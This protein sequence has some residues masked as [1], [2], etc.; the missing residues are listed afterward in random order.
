QYADYALW[1]RELLG[2]EDNPQSVIS[3]QVGYWR[4]A[5]ADAPE[6]LELPFDHQRP[7]V[8]SHQG[9][10]VPFAVPAAVHAQAARVARSE[11]ATT[12]MVLQAALAMVLS[13]SGAGTDIPIGTAVA[14]RTDADLGDL[15]GFFVNTLVMRTD[16][17]G[18]PTFRELLGRARETSLSA[19]AHQEVPFEKL[20]E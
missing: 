16:L 2:D 15:V 9:H 12:F 13:R 8:P 4:D 14:G 7:A 20:V 19:L 3:R 5:L 1:Q 11:G 18:D 10:S 17:S 6:E